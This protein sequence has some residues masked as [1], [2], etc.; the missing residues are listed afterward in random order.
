MK[1]IF[2]SSHSSHYVLTWKSWWLKAEVKN[3]MRVGIKSATHHITIKKLAIWI[4]KLMNETVSET[5]VLRCQ[6]EHPAHAIYLPCPCGTSCSR[7]RTLN[8]GSWLSDDDPSSTCEVTAKEE[9]VI[10][11]TLFQHA[12]P[13]ALNDRIVQDSS[14]HRKTTATTKTMMMI[15]SETRAKFNDSHLFFCLRTNFAIESN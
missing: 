8:F 13:L 9:N 15:V 12:N 11:W 1:N 10:S 2:A 3:C 7:A 14:W 5:V 4:F 6:V